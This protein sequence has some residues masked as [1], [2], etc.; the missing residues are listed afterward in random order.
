MQHDSHIALRAEVLAGI[1]ADLEALIRE[2]R[3]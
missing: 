3:R 2:A 1:K